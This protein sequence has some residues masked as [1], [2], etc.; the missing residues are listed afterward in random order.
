LTTP[1][2]FNEYEAQSMVTA[3]ADIIVAHVGMTTGGTIGATDAMTLDQAVDI[4]MRIADAS[5]RVRKDI[6]V[7]CH[8][9]PFDEPETVEKAL[10]LMPGINGFYGAT[11]M[12]RLP[13]ERAI[14]E[15]V[16]KF[17]EIRTESFKK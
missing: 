12:E 13:V 5:R 15:Q 11:S 2:C 3:G 16:R 4:T 7:I 9:G 17:S 14:T 8:G 6:L 1:Y 10:K